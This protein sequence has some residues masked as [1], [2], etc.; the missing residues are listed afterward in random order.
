MYYS[1][2]RCL[3]AYLLALLFLP[4]F[5]PSLSAVDAEPEKASAKDLLA[6]AAALAQ[7][8]QLEPAL[9]TVSKAIAADPKSVEGYLLRGSIYSH[10]MNYQDAIADLNRALSL[11]PELAEVYDRRGDLH[12]KSGAFKAAVADFDEFLK[13]R[14]ESTPR[15]WR[16]GI[17]YYYVGDYVNGKKQ[18][19]GYQTFDSSD[20]ENAVWRYLCMARGSGV[21]K[22]RSGLLKVGRDARVPMKQ[23]YELFRGDCQAAEVLKAARAGDPPQE[24]LTKYLF[25]AHLYLGLYYEAEGNEELARKHITTAANEYKIGDYMWSVAKVHAGLLRKDRKTGH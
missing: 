18:F 15:H 16:R 8:G 17:A 21:K 4:L 23:I 11:D 3:R 1:E 25:Y 22:A 12:L 2:E 7:V 9:E 24:K 5:V 10:R 14:P 13:R 6:K 20:V 19:E